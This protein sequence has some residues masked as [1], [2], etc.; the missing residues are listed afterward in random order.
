MIYSIFCT[1]NGKVISSISGNYADDE[2]AIATARFYQRS[3]AADT[4]RVHR[5]APLYPLGEMIAEFHSRPRK[6]PGNSFEMRCPKCGD[7]TQIDIAATVWVRLTA[8][9]TDADEAEDGGH[10]WEDDSRA[11]CN[12]CDHQGTAKEFQPEAA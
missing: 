4:I 9:G 1:L 11:R 12:A 8:D 3:S 5:D 10:F 6:E 2:A 7:G